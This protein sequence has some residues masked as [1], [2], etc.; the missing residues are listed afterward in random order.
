MDGQNFTKFQFCSRNPI[1]K[2]EKI[3]DLSKERRLDLQF[4]GIISYF[5]SVSC[6]NGGNLKELKLLAYTG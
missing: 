3:P 5:Y 6:I 1:K 4:F 2:S